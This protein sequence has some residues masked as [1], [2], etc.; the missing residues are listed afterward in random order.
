MVA[1][2][3]VEKYS[4]GEYAKRRAIHILIPYFTLSVIGIVPKLLLSAVLNDSFQAS[5][6]LR[7][8]LVPR[9][10]IW[11]HFWFLPMIFV[12]GVIGYGTMKMTIQEGH[13]KIY[14][15]MLLVVGTTLSFAPTLTG[16]FAVNDIAHFFFI[17]CWALFVARGR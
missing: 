1:T 10:S 2:K 8:F 11:G 15:Y 13:W 12:L 6:L 5:D 14:S 4:F 16:W 17:I 9:E 7:A 3:Q